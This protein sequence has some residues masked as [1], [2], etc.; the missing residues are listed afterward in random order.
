MTLAALL[1]ACRPAEPERVT[2]AK[3]AA[4]EAAATPPAEPPVQ[5]TGA[6]TVAPNPGTPVETHWQCGDQRVVARYDPAA[7][8][9]TLIHERGQL[10]LPQSVSASGARYADANGNEFW[11][12]ES[13]AML[14]LSGTP[15]RECSQVQ[16]GTT[17]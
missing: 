14:T 17:D 1:G 8:A 15:A 11:S 4:A 3:A 12:K 13:G 7:Q 5:P 16:N 6:A 10:T 9:L 2:T